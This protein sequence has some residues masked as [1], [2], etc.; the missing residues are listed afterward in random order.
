MPLVMKDVPYRVW[1]RNARRQSYDLAQTEVYAKIMRLMDEAMKS[2]KAVDF[3]HQIVNPDQ[4]IFST[5]AHPSVVYDTIS[6]TITD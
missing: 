3:A 4:P 6:L 5:R 1:K 2:G